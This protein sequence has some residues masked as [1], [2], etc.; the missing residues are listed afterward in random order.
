ME[1]YGTSISSSRELDCL[2]YRKWEISLG[3]GISLGRSRGEIQI[4]SDALIEKLIR[5]V[6]SNLSQACSLTL[7]RETRWKN[8]EDLGLE[9]GLKEEWNDFVSLS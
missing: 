4:L 6:I 3:R 7:H 2:V 9:E 8:S 5:L 1:G